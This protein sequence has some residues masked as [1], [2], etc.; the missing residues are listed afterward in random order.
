MD[1]Q[2]EEWLQPAGLAT[3]FRQQAVLGRASSLFDK[4]F[5]A[6]ALPSSDYRLRNR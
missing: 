2:R 6:Y 5:T 1:A 3:S 4:R